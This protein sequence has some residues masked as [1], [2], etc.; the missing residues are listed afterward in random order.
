MLGCEI[1]KRQKRLREKNSYRI[2]VS[3]LGSVIVSRKRVRVTVT[4]VT[5]RVRVLSVSD[6][7]YGEKAA[8]VDVVAGSIRPHRR[9]CRRRRRLVQWRGRPEHRRRVVLVVHC[10]RGGVLRGGGVVR[11]VVGGAVLVIC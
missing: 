7:A 2:V 9:R 1:C 5:R 6:P 3:G 8:V 10:G 4:A 11:G